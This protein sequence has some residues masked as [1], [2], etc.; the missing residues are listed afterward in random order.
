MYVSLPTGV[1]VAGLRVTVPAWSTDGAELVT[2]QVRDEP[3]TGRSSVS[4]TRTVSPTFTWMVRPASGWPTTT[5][6]PAACTWWGPQH[7]DKPARASAARAIAI[8]C[9]FEI[10]FAAAGA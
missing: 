3:G 7:A 1:M 4:V 9:M 8:R 10:T 5:M 2:S 6:V